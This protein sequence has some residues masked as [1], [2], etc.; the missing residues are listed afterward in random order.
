MSATDESCENEFYAQLEDIM[1]K[2]VTGT[3][4]A[5]GSSLG[6]FDIMSSYEKPQTIDTIAAKGN[7]KP[8]YVRI[9]TYTKEVMFSPGFVC[10]FVS[11]FVC[12]Q[13][14]SKSYGQIMDLMD[15]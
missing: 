3:C 7:W 6:I 10:G 15:P 12:E 8:R 2:S 4:I 1:C 11:L 9:F 14:N 5:L 13:D